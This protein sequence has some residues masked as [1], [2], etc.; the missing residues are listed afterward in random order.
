MHSIILKVGFLLFLFSTA[1]TASSDEWVNLPNSD[2]TVILKGKRITASHVRG[3][4]VTLQFRDNGTLY[5]NHSS[6]GAD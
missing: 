1:A 4:Q 3:G 6:G 2:L 5:G